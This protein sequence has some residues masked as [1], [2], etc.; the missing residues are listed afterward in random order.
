MKVGGFFFVLVNAGSI[1]RQDMGMTELSRRTFMATGAAAV[2]GAALVSQTETAQAVQ[3]G[4][5]ARAGAPNVVMITVDEMRFPQTFPAGIKT[6]EE[7]LKAF[8]PNLAKLWTRGVKFSNHYTAGT[9]CSPSRASLVTGLYPH[10]NWCLQT[11]KG[12]QPGSAGPNAP[13]LQ[14]EFPTYGKL[15]REAGYATPYVG[16]WHLSNAPETSTDPAAPFYLSA[17][18]FEG[19]TIPDPIGTNGQGT[20]GDGDIAAQAATWLE[21]RKPH[22]RPF[23]LTVGFVNP[24]DK[25]FFWS[26]T[27]ATT[28]NN[29][30]K[31][32]GATAAVT[33]DAAPPLD[34]PKAYGYTLPA[35][36][37]SAATLAANKPG[38]QVFA[39][40]FTDLMWGGVTDDPTVTTAY[41]LADYPGVP[42]AKIANAPFGYWTRSLDSYTQI[43][44]LVDQHIGAVVNSIPESIRDNTV[45]IMTADHG[46]YAGA[47]GFASNKAGSMY[48]EAVQVPLIVVDPRERIT[49]DTNKV[50]TQLTSSVDIVP[51]L[52][53][54]AHGDREWLKGDLAEVYQERLNLL[55]LLKSNTARG[56][57][58]V[59]MASDEW[60]PGFYVYNNARRHILGIR[61]ADT[62]VASY[63]NWNTTGV[64][65][66]STMQVES[67]DYSTARG[68]LELDNQQGQTAKAQEQLKLLMGRYN[69]GAMAAPLP[70]R[71]RGAVARG[72]S[73][74]LA[75]IAFLDSLNANGSS[76]I[77]RPNG[78]KEYMHLG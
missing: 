19:L 63:T 52:A 51:M 25:E 67:Y 65:D 48:Q 14:R 59:I 24:H 73:E 75:Y 45:I 40:S 18:G 50:R 70:A 6:P 17:Y 44:N 47:H 55:P 30:F 32:A 13:A 41:S 16:K 61:T 74:Y 22:E 35:N 49:G 27:E 9:A 12:N 28:Y 42:G 56:R 38:A 62:K 78:I 20:Y 36:W 8:M 37:E 11:R 57:D 68:R 46:D 33:Y 3:A 31:R 10:Q 1:Q 66:L 39:R 23:C 2:A 29:L 53:T 21:A 26:G 64:A 43:L 5:R 58:H 77:T 76:N 4:S 60:V 54:I 15:M 7:F 34:T 71:F 69:R 72:K